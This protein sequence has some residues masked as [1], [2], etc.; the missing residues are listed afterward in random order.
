MEYAPCPFLRPWESCAAYEDTRAAGQR[1]ASHSHLS[2]LHH[3]AAFEHLLPKLTGRTLLFVGD[4]I[5][6]QL[7]V[8]FACSLHATCPGCLREFNASWTKP[9][10]DR[11]STAKRCHGQPQCDFT[12]ACITWHAN[13]ANGSSL[14]KPKRTMQLKMRRGKEIVMCTCDSSKWV[15]A[16]GV[17]W[18]KHREVQL[19]SPHVGKCMALFDHLRASDVIVYGSAGLHKIAWVNGQ[20]QLLAHARQEVDTVLHSLRDTFG[21]RRPYLLW[22]E[23]TAQHFPGPAGFFSRVRDGVLHRGAN[24]YRPYRPYAN[25]SRCYESHS[26]ATMRDGNGWNMHANALLAAAGVPILRAW[27]PSSMASGAHIGY[28]D[29]THFCLPGVPDVWAMLLADALHSMADRDLPAPS[30][31]PSDANSTWICNDGFAKAGMPCY[32]PPATQ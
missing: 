5:H 13:A 28:G 2:A 24:P 30:G 16:R 22:R 19:T 31:G 6:R 8:A 12:G 26:A 11:R 14:Y 23:L 27:L 29:C 21:P 7:F 10:K 9:S 25:S 1:A 18:A 20:N 32:Y 4:S 17:G 15:P 3:G